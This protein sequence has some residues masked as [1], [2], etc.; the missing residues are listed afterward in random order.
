MRKTQRNERILSI[1]AGILLLSILLMIIIIPG[2]LNDTHPNALPENAAITTFVGIL[3]HLIIFIL[4]IKFIY[5][6]KIPLFVDL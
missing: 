2:L 1:A 6:S 3:M 4:Y 5:F